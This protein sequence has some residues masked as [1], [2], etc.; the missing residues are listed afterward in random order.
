[1]EHE[2]KSDPKAFADVQSGDKK[3][4]IRVDDR[5]PRYAVGDT[6]WL[7]EW[8][9]PR[10]I[11]AGPIMNAST[12]LGNVGGYT[13]EE[14]RR[15]VTHIQRGYGLPDT[16]VAMSIELIETEDDTK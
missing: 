1:M 3:A 10:H 6:L 16:Y 8:E 13:G 9:P 14:L 15:R 7:R 11:Q 12:C 4:E 5:T 2:L